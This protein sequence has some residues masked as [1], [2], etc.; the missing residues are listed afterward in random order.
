MGGDFVFE[1][2]DFR[3]DVFASAQAFDGSV[4]I[5]VA[6]GECPFVPALAVLLQ[7]G[8]LVSHALDLMLESIELHLGVSGGGLEFVYGARNYGFVVFDLAD[9]GVESG[10]DAGG[11]VF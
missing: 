6:Q 8:A 9:D 4:F 1:V 11:P 5:R 2:S 7:F 10:Y 3:F